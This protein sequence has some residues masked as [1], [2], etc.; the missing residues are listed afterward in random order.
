MEQALIIASG[1]GLNGED[2]NLFPQLNVCEVQQLKRLL[3]NSERAGISRF[4]I[5]CSESSKLSLL[6]IVNDRR[7]QSQTDFVCENDEYKFA[8]DSA[9]V[10]QSNLLTYSTT[11]K[12]FFDST[13]GESGNAVLA[14]SENNLYGLLKLKKT[15]INKILKEADLGELLNPN[16]KKHLKHVAVD[17]GYMMNLAPNQESLDSAKE[18]IFS[19]VGKTATGWIA[20]NIN[21]R[22]S[23]PLSRHLIKTPL[24]PNM[25]SVLINV[26]GIMSGP[27]FALGHPVIGAICM[28]IATI[29]DRCDGEVA[30]IKLMETKKGQWVDTISDQI[31]M[32]SFYIGLPIGYYAVNNSGWIIGLGIM[33][34]FFFLF[35]IAWS[36]YFLVKFTDS[37]SLVSYMKVDNFIDTEKTSSMR[38]FISFLRPLGRR[39]FYSMA[40][41]VMAILGGYPVVF[42]FATVAITFFFLHVL[43]DIVKLSKIKKRELLN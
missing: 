34:V 35:F 36:F 37:G 10:I 42:F 4:T 40:F 2:L 11:L 16:S 6:K 33:N 19:N 30:R 13:G 21:G 22:F 9:Y 41:L 28:Q 14:D 29:L 20:V 5:F 27:F 1:I 7:I 15:E 32:L 12:S 23:L 3:I 31:S 25:I 43:E 18:M 17:E 24:T 8:D 39:N 26:I 38:K